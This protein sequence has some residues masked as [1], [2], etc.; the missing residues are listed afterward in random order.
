MTDAAVSIGLADAYSGPVR[1][2]P[3]AVIA[4]LLALAG[5]LVP[6]LPPLL[7]LFLAGPAKRNVRASNGRRRGQPVAVAAQIIA[8]IVLLLNVGAAASIANL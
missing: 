8:P 3:A 6:V 1:T 5:L 4:L 2:E 7:A